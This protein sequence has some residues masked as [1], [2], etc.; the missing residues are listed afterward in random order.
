MV[1]S[2]NIGSHVTEKDRPILAYLE[3][4][5]LDLHDKG[6]GYTLTFKFEENAYMS[7]K[8]ITKKFIMS[9]S[10]VIEKSVG[11]EIV[12]TQGSNP[13]MEK[14]KKK[15]KVG[16]KKKTVTKEVKCDSFFNFFQTVELTEK[17]KKAKDDKGTGS[18][19]DEDDED[20]VG[21]QMDED[22]EF[23]NEFKEDLIP[24]ALEYYLGV[25]EQESDDEDDDDED[26]ADKDDDSED[27]KPKKKKGKGGKGGKGGAD[28]MAG[29]TDK[30]KEECK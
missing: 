8:T 5:Q 11:T 18:D 2:K 24:L 29:A 1:G 12:W 16:G 28:P 26:G 14:K 20:D 30:Q 13:C 22:F 25:I 3:D 9:K 19:D 10:N 15:I 4:I 21:E 7:N 27:E 23:G 17:D 6:Q